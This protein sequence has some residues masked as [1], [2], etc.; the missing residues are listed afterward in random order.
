MSADTEAFEK[1]QQEHDARRRYLE[2]KLEEARDAGN[3]PL[4]ESLLEQLA[5][6]AESAPKPTLRMT[7]GRTPEELDESL[8]GTMERLSPQ[9]RASLDAQASSYATG[10]DGAV[11]EG[12]K[13]DWLWG[14]FADLPPAERLAAMRAAAKQGARP[15]PMRVAAGEGTAGGRGSVPGGGGSP[16]PRG[17]R[18][19]ENV[20]LHNDEPVRAG[21]GT[22]VR[23]GSGA[24][25]SRAPNMD[26]LEALGVDAQGNG[27]DP[28]PRVKDEDWR[29][30]MLAIGI[31]GFGLDRSQY[32]EGRAGEDQLVADTQRRLARHQERLANGWETET[33]VTGGTRYRPV[34]GGKAEQTTARAG[35]QARTRD[36]LRA[37]AVDPATA[38]EMWKEAD[39]GVAPSAQT[40]ALR[41]RD[42]D[43]RN[44]LSNYR[45]MQQWARQ[46]QNPAMA[47]QMLRA[48]LAQAGDDLD[49]Q[50]AV[51]D[52]F[53]LHGPADRLRAHKSAREGQAGKAQIEQQLA[54][55]ETTKAEAAEMAASGKEAPPDAGTHMATTRNQALDA[56]DGEGGPNEALAI[57]STGHNQLAAS[58]PSG[59]QPAIKPQEAALPVAQAIVRSPGGIN[60]ANR[61]VVVEMAVRQLWDKGVPS[62]DRGTLEVSNAWGSAEQFAEHVAKMLGD[63]PAVRA[64]AINMYNSIR[65]TRSLPGGSGPRPDLPVATRA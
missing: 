47:Q 15:A 25:S 8:D 50:A 14:Q 35:R 42:N 1:A 18:N 65:G 40:Q 5:Q 29:Q 17:R 28:N 16:P 3:V 64:M 61:R 2:T 55:A 12:A 19:P 52:Q 60:S 21:A 39:G 6:H 56:L 20:D 51:M 38:R 49:A 63:T 26:Q 30:R 45:E 13:Q 37:N 41:Q 43:V 59:K 24:M 33:L 54:D 58:D 57:Y 48:S 46:F 32:A 23:T 7:G 31:S 34:A 36:F 10:Q 9:E 22:M 27:V 53:G 4:Q 62:Q 44:S 11:N